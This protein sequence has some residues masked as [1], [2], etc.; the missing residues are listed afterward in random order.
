MASVKKIS[1]EIFK[2]AS[3]TYYNLHNLLYLWMFKV[4]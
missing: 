4:W 1:F 2:N 3:E